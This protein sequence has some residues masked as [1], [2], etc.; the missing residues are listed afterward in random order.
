MSLVQA[1]KKA[2]GNQSQAARILNINLVTVRNRMKKYR[3]DLTKVLTSQS[4][5]I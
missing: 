3:I 5:I 2:R 1:L 4:G